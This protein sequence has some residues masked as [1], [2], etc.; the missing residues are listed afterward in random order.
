MDDADRYFYEDD[1]AI[2][3]TVAGDVTNADVPAAECR[4]YESARIRVISGRRSV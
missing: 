4:G 3:T 2:D 1:P